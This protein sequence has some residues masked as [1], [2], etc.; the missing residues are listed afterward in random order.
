VN[1]PQT[2]NKADQ[3]QHIHEII[4]C[5]KENLLSILVG[6]MSLFSACTIIYY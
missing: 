2:P 3:K 1:K 6:E 4:N 5:L